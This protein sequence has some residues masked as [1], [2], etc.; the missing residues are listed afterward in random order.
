[1]NDEDILFAEV[2][3]ESFVQ[4]IQERNFLEKIVSF[5]TPQK[6]VFLVNSSMIQDST[7]NNNAIIKLARDA[8]KIINNDFNKM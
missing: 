7:L 5:R 8:V 1:M 3:R 2:F 6:N 4:P